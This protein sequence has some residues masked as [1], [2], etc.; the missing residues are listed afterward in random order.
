MYK[1]NNNESL[2]LEAQ[3]G[4]G[5]AR[6]IKTSVICRI[7][8]TSFL[9]ICTLTFFGLFDFVK[10][11]MVTS[12]LMGWRSSSP[13]IVEGTQGGLAN[14]ASQTDFSAKIVSH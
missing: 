12:R 3:G 14:S 2:E 6:S 10:V 4:G 5:E 11:D 9:T 8:N 7:N 13:V 1:N